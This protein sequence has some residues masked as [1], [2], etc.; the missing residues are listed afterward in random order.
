MCQ[1]RRQTSVREKEV[2]RH[3]GIPTNSVVFMSQKRPP[4]PHTW[5]MLFTHYCLR[6]LH[7]PHSHSFRHFP[8]TPSFSLRILYTAPTAR[9]ATYTSQHTARALA[10]NSF[11]CLLQSLPLLLL[12]SGSVLALRLH[13]SAAQGACGGDDV[14]QEKGLGRG[15]GMVVG[16]Y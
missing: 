7:I 5:D 15:L 13:A 10:R 11:S 3:A 6:L 8:L 9:C 2:T 4:I 1:T 14:N 16:L 12:P